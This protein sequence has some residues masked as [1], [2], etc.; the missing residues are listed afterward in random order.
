MK[1]TFFAVLLCCLILPGL[2]MAQGV[3]SAAFNGLVTDV[4]GNP[5]VG[6]AITAL[7]TPTGTVYTAVSRID[8]LFNIPAVRVGGPYTVTF[9]M[10]PFKTQELKG[11]T[12]KLGEDRNLKIKLALE[13]IAEEITVIA[14]NPIISEG[15]TGASQNV[16]TAII[17]S[18]PSIGR[19]FDDFARLAPQVDPRGSGAYSA[20]GKSSRYNNI[21]IDGAVNNDLFGLGSSGTPGLATPI[22]LD[23]VQEFQLVIAPYDVRHGGF[24]GASLNAITRSGTNAFSGSA[25]YFGR[26]QDFVGKGP[27]NKAYGAFTEKQYG[28]RLGGPIVKDKL[29]FFLSGEMGDNK[30]PTNWVIDDSGSSNDFGGTNVNKADA[31]RFISILKNKYG[32]DP[33][34]YGEG[35]K[36]VIQDNSKLF[37]RMDYNISDKHRL[38]LR[39]NYV[40]GSRDNNPSKA[41][42]YVFPFGDVYYELTNT[43]NSTV[44][45]LNSTLG[46]NLFNEFIVNYTT[47]RD[48]RAV[49]DKR[50]PQVNVAIAGG[51]RL[52]AGTEQYS[53]ANSLDQDI[54]ELTD[55]LTWYKGKHTF[56]I[57]THNEFFNFGNVYI[58]NY[59]GY[60]EFNSLNDFEIGKASRYYHDFYTSNPKEKWA[61]KF[62]VM[63]LGAYAGDNWAVLPNLTLTIGLR[64][65]VPIINDIP[66]ANPK[67]E[68]I[69]GIKT[70]QAASGNLLFSPRIGFNW[71]VNKDKKTQVRGGIGIF[72]GRTPYVWISNQYSNTGME[73]TRFDLRNPVFSFVP[74]AS[75]QPESGPGLVSG[76]SEVDI[77][78]ENFTYPQ[79]LRTNLAVDQELPWGVIGTLEF[80]YSRNIN[81]ILYQN[82]NLRKTGA[83]AVGGRIMF[84]RDFSKS[85]TDVIYLTNS[86]KGYQY[87][88]S[89]QFQKSFNKNSWANFSYAYGEAKDVNSGTSSQASSNFVYNPIRFDANDP[90]LTWS[91]YDVRHRIGAAISYTF[92]F[93]KDAPT[94]IGLFYGARSGRPYSTTYNY[95]DANGDTA[96]GNDL[97]Y[98]PAS[99]NDVI[100]VDSSGNVIA[101]QNKA[102]NELNA[103]IGEDPG[104]SD[105][106]G[107]IVPR[108]ASREPWYHGLDA[109]LAQ[110]IPVPGLKDHRLQITLDVVNVLNLLNN[111]WGKSW[112]VSNQND[113]P[114]TLKGIDAATGK[115]KVNFAPR[116]H[117]VLSQLGSRWQMQ[118]G[119]RYSFN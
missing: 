96:A 43:T 54:I 111:E 23:A 38:T 88:L 29:F 65:D 28:F 6:A 47:I 61:A 11:I 78:D 25:Y 114:W 50:F 1:R 36:D 39:H 90:E 86:T 55:N 62:G 117:Y 8:G 42:S 66:A 15:R 52:T 26:N 64:L 24:T 63:Q 45:Q 75:N 72:S 98:V 44:A 101:D 68:Q 113:T 80:I 48:S 107:K 21:Q 31:D 7:H 89:A 56:T 59:N 14:S 85:F 60:W 103:F 35:Y 40:T 106:R 30:V 100:M 97:V 58:R 104:L 3:T 87:T 27:D 110:D 34:G 10:D 37:L 115:Q 108:N 17:E 99:I 33:G 53:G 12:L 5:I 2:A 105:Y 71:D 32:Y 94:S 116:A 4:D 95:Y 18:M 41:S 112:Y 70:N 67:V 13:T 84:A 46:N 16:S 83:T 69:Y 19:S 93:L 74:D 9:K 79:V 82:L 22:S 76:T 102:W 77:I 49:G 119:L 73:F 118:L 51:Y 20:A 109:R 57:G 92:N 91:N 81:E